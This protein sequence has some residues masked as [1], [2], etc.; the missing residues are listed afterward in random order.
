MSNSSDG[1][2]GGYKEPVPELSFEKF[3]SSL[4]AKAIAYKKTK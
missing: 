3:I 4:L 1:V 2:S